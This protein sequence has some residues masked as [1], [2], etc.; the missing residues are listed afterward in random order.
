MKKKLTCNICGQEFQNEQQ[1][2]WHKS[3]H[4]A[5]AVSSLGKGIL[6]IVFFII[7]V[8]ILLSLMH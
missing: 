7:L 4:T 5:T 8:I 3:Q 6:G 1:L 2:K